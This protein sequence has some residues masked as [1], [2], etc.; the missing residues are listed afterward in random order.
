MGVGKL[1]MGVGKSTIGV[2]KSTI[3]VGNM[4]KKGADE[5]RGKTGVNTDERPL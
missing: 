4:V 3:G 1:T 2:G 5:T